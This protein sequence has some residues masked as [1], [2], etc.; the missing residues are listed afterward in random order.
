MF[1][2]LVIPVYNRPHEMD[3]LLESLCHLEHKDFEVVIV[4]DGSKVSSKPIAERYSQKLS[5]KYISQNNTGP[6]L[7]RN[8]GAEHS[9]ANW[10]IFLD[11]DTII[12]KDYLNKVDDYL[13]QN[14]IDVFG[15]ADTAMENF[16]EIQKAISYAMTSFFTTG[17]IR[18]TKGKKMDKFFPRSFNMGITRSVFETTGGFSKLRFGEDIDFS[19]RAI[20]YGF[21][22]AFIEDAFVYH[23]RRTDRKSFFKQVF[24]SGVARINLSMRHKKTLKIVH[25]LPAAFVL[26]TILCLLTLTLY[27]LLLVAALW[28]VDS[29][30]KYNN[31]NIAI[32]SIEMSFIQILGYG[33]GFLYGVYNRL[34]LRKPEDASYNTTFF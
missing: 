8:K 19:Y 33:L 28:F 6:G 13:S 17:G 4:E 31:V 20:A 27:P 25:C 34:I 3:E 24:F 9:S 18:G 23:K 15:G 5:I 32:L 22:T 11:S 30:N 29:L 16:S 10:I 26:F 1:Y 7:A 2:S 14:Q 21:K 12:P